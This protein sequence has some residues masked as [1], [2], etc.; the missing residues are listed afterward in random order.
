MIV[1]LQKMAERYKANELIYKSV[2][3]VRLGHNCNF[4]GQIK[5]VW[6]MN[7]GTVIHSRLN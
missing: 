3:L 1:Y 5:I 4:K 2:Y 7:S 6:G